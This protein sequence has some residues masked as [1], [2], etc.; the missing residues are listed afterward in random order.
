MRS[1]ISAVLWNPNGITQDKL[2]WLFNIT[3]SLNP[4]LFCLVES[5]ITPDDLWI[6]KNFSIHSNSKAHAGVSIIYKKTLNLK[7]IQSSEDGRLITFTT[8]TAHEISFAVA[9]W[10]A[11]SSHSVKKRFATDHSKKFLGADIIAADFNWVE[12]EY[13]DRRNPNSKESKKRTFSN[14]TAVLKK[15]ATK[16]KKDPV[17]PFI[18]NEVNFFS[19]KANGEECSRID[20]I[21]G[22]TNSHLGFINN[23]SFP[24]GKSCHCPVAFRFG[25]EPPSNRPWTFS[26][27]LWT[28]Q[29]SK[30]YLRNLIPPPSD[31]ELNYCLFDQYLGRVTDTIQKKE[32]EIK[33]KQKKLVIKARKLIKKIPAKLPEARKLSNFLTNYEK[34]V[35]KKKKLLAGKKWDIH[36]ETPSK[37]LTSLLKSM[38]AK[39]T[40]TEIYKPGTHDIVRDEKGISDAFHSFYSNLYKH[41]EY[42]AN[43][44]KTFL[45]EWDVPT[46]SKEDRNMLKDSFTMKEL[47]DALKK[48]KDLKAP[49]SNG[50]PSLPFKKLSKD[51][52]KVLLDF[53]NKAFNNHEIP[54]SWKEGIITTIYKKGD[55][56][57]IANR[58][59][60]TLLQTQY[61]ILSKMVTNRLNKIVR[62]FINLDQ[63]GFMNE[64]L[65]Y[66]NV[67]VAHEA[68]SQEEKYVI[69]VDFKKAFDSVAHDSIFATLEHMK[70][71]RNYIS[72]IKSMITDSTARV[73][74]NDSLTEAFKIARGV[75]QGDPLSPLLFAI[76]I[77]PLAAYIR[78]N[79]KGTKLGDTYQKI[80]LYADDILLFA[81]DLVEQKKYI[82]LMEN[83]RKASGLE[84]NMD[85]SLH[86]SSHS[87]NIGIPAC[88][89]EG[90]RYLGFQMGISGI[91]TRTK[92]I[93]KSIEKS[94][95]TWKFFAY[96]TRTKAT[97]LNSY[98]MSKLWFYSFILDFDDNVPQ[99]D[100]LA[101]DFLWKK[102][103][104]GKISTRYKMRQERTELPRKQGGL[105]LFHLPS[106]FK[107]QKAWI[108]NFALNGNSKIGPIYNSRY[109]FN[110]D[111]LSPNT[112]PMVKKFWE[113]YRTAK[114]LDKNVPSKP[115]VQTILRK[116]HKAD[117]FWNPDS[118]TCTNTPNWKI[119][120]KFQYERPP[121]KEHEPSLEFIP[122]NTE[123]DNQPPTT[124][125]ART[126]KL[127][128]K[129]WAHLFRGDTQPILT[130]RQLKLKNNNICDPIELFNNV[131][132]RIHNIPAKDFFWN[133][134][135]GVLYFDRAQPCKCKST[136]TSHN[137]LFFNCDKVQTAFNPIVKL[138]LGNQTTKPLWE[139]HQILN[140]LEKS[141]SNFE[142]AI[143]LNIM[144][145]IWQSKDLDHFPTTKFTTN[146]ESIM[147][148]DWFFAKNHLSKNRN[149][150]D[151]LR[152]FFDNWNNWITFDKKLKI[153]IMKVIPILE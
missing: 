108:A 136:L 106:R 70:L 81:T 142:C 13:R 125:K 149:S 135:N 83:F 57:D 62:D 67:L 38:D 115:Q 95:S 42:D 65:I 126:P 132:R 124:K 150:R 112:P 41:Q 89:P 56:L 10:P 86:L 122:L 76:V 113:A 44:H 148:S 145:T 64:R 134:I 39:T 47:E 100:K 152:N 110:N 53:C 28:S 109:G 119:T 118:K 40:I 3:E 92:D 151:P 51:G 97:I 54:T 66:D 107:G 20:R 121:H 140:R 36:N 26:P 59:P 16:G 90:F 130:N 25:A 74:V 43:A 93:L 45:K 146:L 131:S 104:K 32:A 50:L 11:N 35:A 153:P 129:F 31:D 46:L 23:L 77:E 6:P 84:M 72:L 79:F 80:L 4:S 27:N 87:E 18:N 58:R 48:M 123:A 71:P 2:S 101:K 127:E 9:Y 22:N 60:I 103:F 34:Q 61:K 82:Q 139:E 117:L 63:V 111:S 52:K 14:S 73:R 19:N 55:E 24:E 17:I 98:I 102:S 1:P 5:H 96:R 30:S 33:R 8:G 147:I 78:K 7:N 37:L 128:L 68:L 141:R 144:Q 69:S 94:A 105:G 143:I 88:P 116:K 75:K 120:T 15:K 91:M 12:D 138:Y 85:K 29:R 133:Y 49:G 114:S 99:L 137:H 21:Y